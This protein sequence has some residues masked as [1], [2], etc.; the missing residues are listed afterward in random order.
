M[1]LSSASLAVASKR[2]E[3]HGLQDMVRV[4][5]GSLLPEVDVVVSAQ[6]SAS[7]STEAAVAADGADDTDDSGAA[8]RNRGSG[9][10]KSGGTSKA[11]GDKRTSGGDT[12]GARTAMG[13]DTPRTSR[14][15]SQA[16]QLA[17]NLGVVGAAG[18]FDYIDC[19]GVLMATS[20]PPRALFNLASLLKP[21]GGMGIMV[22]GALGRAP[23]YQI[24]TM[25]R[26]LS[27]PIRGGISAGAGGG[28]GGDG[29]FGY[30]HA[31]LDT[32]EQLEALWAIMGRN[33]GG[34]SV[35][36]S[37]SSSSLYGPNFWGQRAG[38]HFD[39]NGRTRE[40]DVDLVRARVC[41]CVCVCV[42]VVRA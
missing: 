3:L 5:R 25:M 42:C 8:A 11:G 20:D 22:Y 36:S 9:A 13:G 33:E 26:M 28:G 29:E 30:Q 2:F 32:T 40:Q 14:G 31:A 4:V 21:D 38:F 6:P 18:R 27:R 34:S 1:D 17:A 12:R 41:V 39:P 7:S 35:A 23:V 19:V 24:R 37:S 15:D 10:G 16:A